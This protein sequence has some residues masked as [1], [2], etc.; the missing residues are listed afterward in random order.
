[1]VGNGPI[2]ATGEASALKAAIDA[3]DVDAVRRL[4]SADPALHVAPIGYAGDGPL[5]WAAECRVPRRAPRAARLQLVEW[6]IKN[7]SDVH[8][9]GDAPLM[10]AALDDERIAMLELLLE[11]GADVDAAWHGE[12]P[13]VFAP[14]EALAVGALEWLLAHGADPDCGSQARWAALGRQHPGTALDFLD[15]TYLD[16]AE[17]IA[18]CAAALT[19]AGGTRRRPPA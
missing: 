13:I 5:T 15:R 18:A 3:D 16:D 8:Q 7:G 11:H 6:M 9:G 14:C 2:S 19:R 4:M 17:R 12:Y 10:R 1:M